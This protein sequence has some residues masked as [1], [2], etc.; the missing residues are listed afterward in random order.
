MRAFQQVGY[1]RGVDAVQLATDVPAPTA[2]QLPPGHLLV[3]V[4]ASALNYG[5]A[6]LGRG[7][8]RKIFNIV[9]PSII[10]RDV[11]GVVEAVNDDGGNSNSDVPS[12]N[13]G[14]DISIRPKSSFKVGD[15]VVAIVP[16]GKGRGT[17]AE[18]I[19]IDPKDAEHLPDSI[20]F[21]DAAA[22]PTPG[23]TTYQAIVGQAATGVLTRHPRKI[24]VLGGST[25]TGQIALQLAK[26]VAQCSEI[27]TT[28]SQAELCKSLGA[29]V[30]I[31]HR[32]GEDWGEVL[33]GQNF[34]VIYDCIEGLQ[35]WT[36]ASRVLKPSGGEFVS[37]VMDDTQGLN[38]DQF[39]RWQTD[40]SFTGMIVFVARVISRKFWSNFGYPSYYWYVN[41]GTTAGL[42]EL[43]D[44]MTH[45]QLRVVLDPDN[46]GQPYA[47][48]MQAFGTMWQRQQ[49]GRS[50][51]RM[52]IKW[53]D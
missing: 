12:S 46:N 53:E 21:C 7:G 36:K 39:K 49:S 16:V 4:K 20:N 17:F 37:I 50:H 48:T 8:A 33:A 13:S 34:D 23:C 15:R 28:S 27:A 29:T 2:E 51:G 26:A 43:L 47:P 25:S 31:N 41:V 44:L 40:P 30:V 32:A 18:H 10:G 19:I 1:S 24:L 5:D 35:A 9:L 38:A 22:L 14:P 6:F 52:V 45:G 3:R 42:R 11:A